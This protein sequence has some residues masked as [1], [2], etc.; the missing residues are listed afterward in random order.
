MAAYTGY[1]IFKS[2]KLI[3]RQKL[4]LCLLAT[5]PFLY[6]HAQVTE[7]FSDG[8]FTSNPTWIGNTAD[9]IVNPSFQL[10]SN[11]LVANAGYYLSTV[12]TKATTTQWDFSCTITFNPSSAN[13]VDVFLTASASD[14]SLSTTAGYFVRIGGTDDV[15]SGKRR[16][17]LT[18]SGK[19]D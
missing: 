11:N 2:N 8:D 3:M 9:W 19:Y 4:L 1:C 16:Q 6:T 5:F 15:A 14:L 17:H 7:N 18:V 12:N 10:Q 13:Y